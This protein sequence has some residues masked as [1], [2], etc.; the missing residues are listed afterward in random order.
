MKLIVGLGNPGIRYR[1]SRH[2]AGF[3]VIDRISSRHGIA[4]KKKRF[5]ALTG[6]GTISGERVVL[7]RP[8]IFMNRSGPPVRDLLKSEKTG[9]RELLVVCDDCDLEPGVIRLRRRGGS[10]GHNGLASIIE[11]LGTE[12]F[13][14]LRIGVG[15]SLK[16]WDLADYVLR[17]F[18]RRAWKSTEKVLQLAADAACFWVSEGIEPAMNKY[19][20]RQE[21]LP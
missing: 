21:V 6:A 15:R 17:P 19:N 20:S 2:N 12:D 5:G 10:G 14:R 9:L 13:S 18:P 3:L 8:V 1:R 11:A 7:A 4:V 16:P